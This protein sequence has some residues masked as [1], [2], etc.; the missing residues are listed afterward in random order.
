MQLFSDFFQS[1]A[2]AQMDWRTLVMYAII[3]LLFYLALVK[4]FEPM[5]LIPISFGMLLTNIPGAELFHME[6]FLRGN[7]LYAGAA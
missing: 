6:L 7:R 4:K 1:T 3:I 2:I 5:L